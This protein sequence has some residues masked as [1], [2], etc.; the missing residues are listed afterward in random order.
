MRELFGQGEWLYGPLSARVYI[1]VGRGGSG[2]RM[3]GAEA[4]AATGRAFAY[5]GTPV[6][7]EEE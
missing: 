3:W 2:A 4:A 5:E 7:K 6:G 1:L